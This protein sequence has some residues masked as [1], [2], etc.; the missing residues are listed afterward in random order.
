[1]LPRSSSRRSDAS[2]GHGNSISSAQNWHHLRRCP[3]TGTRPHGQRAASEWI[4]ELNAKL[5][6]D[7]DGNYVNVMQREGENSVRRAYGVNYARLQQ[8]KA[9]YDPE[10]LFSLNQNIRPAG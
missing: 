4:E 2:A 7:E 5:P 8:I 10:N 3:P 1:M 9:V 6:V